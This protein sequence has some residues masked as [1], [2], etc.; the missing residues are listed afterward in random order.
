MANYAT[1][2]AAIA[3]V[4]KQNG[5]KE[6]TGDLLQQQL[7][8]MVNSLGVGYQ[9]VGIATPDTNPGTPDQNV[10]YIAATTGTYINFNN[11]VVD[12]QIAILKWNGTWTKETTGIIIGCDYMPQLKSQNLIKSGGV[13]D[14]I[15]DESIKINEILGVQEINLSDWEQGAWDQNGNSI[16]T[17]YNFIHRTIVDISSFVGFDII[18]RISSYDQIYCVFKDKNNNKI[19]SFQTRENYLAFTKIRVP[20]G[21]D[22]LYISNYDGSTGMPTEMVKLCVFPE[23]ISGGKIYSESYGLE[24]QEI[25]PIFADGYCLSVAA[26]GYSITQSEYETE[27]ILNFPDGVK[28]GEQY[29]LRLEEP[30]ISDSLKRN[31][32]I[33][34]QSPGISAIKG[35]EIPNYVHKL[36]GGNTW[37][38]WQIIIPR[39]CTKFY[40]ATS[41]HE[42][43][44]VHVYKV[45]RKSLW[46]LEFDLER[47]SLD[48]KRQL[49][50][51]LAFPSFL[52][53][54]IYKPITFNGKT[55]VAFGDSITYGY[56]SGTTTTENPYIKLFCAAA[57]ATLS[58]KAVSGSTIIHRNSN[59]IID[60]ILAF[61]G[62]ADIIWIAGGT[63]DFDLGLTIGHW[64][65]ATNETLYGA[66]KII[67]EYLNA[68][69]PN[70][71]IIWMTPVPYPNEQ[72][73]TH[74]YNNLDY[75]T[76]AIFEVATYYGHSVICG[77]TLGMP[78]YPGAWS[79]LMCQDGQHPTELGHR[80][81]ARSLCGKLL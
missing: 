49:R 4:I 37:S 59:D 65:D 32:F 42:Q 8:A 66:L 1:L 16:L 48:V 43:S 47:Q 44:L 81:M 52:M 20:N 57:N 15:F 62:S 25:I 14:A 31:Y 72:N 21:S 19:S 46:W 70:A 6:I 27:S 23:L 51:V 55:L 75:Y 40:S 17:Q 7:L 61:N 53:D 35:N 76:Q 64:G 39:G 78:N 34:E 74:A 50:N 36:R 68:N 69:Y 60:K 29:I 80:L 3:A 22:K 13:Y 28:E 45:G 58:N 9:Y 30:D 10:Y 33:F 56:T 71:K 73:R 11:I 38:E 5:N 79:S 77:K 54:S 12:N 41:V 26:N 2:K 24:E 18:I 63:N 67:C